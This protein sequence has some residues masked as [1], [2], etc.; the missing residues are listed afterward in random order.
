MN[1]NDVRQEW[2]ERSGEYSPDYYAYYGPDET[3]EWIQSALEDAVDTDARILELGCSS[4]RHLAHLL[5]H[6]YQNLHGIDINEEAFTVMEDAYP[7]LAEQGTFTVDAIESFLPA[8]D[9][10]EFDVVYSVET[11]QHIHPDDSH[12][13]ADIARVASDLVATVEIEGPG[14]D[15]EE[16]V[17]SES[18]ESEAEVN[19][20]DDDV[21]LYYRN[22]ESVFTELGLVQTAS[23]TNRRDTLRAFRP[24]STHP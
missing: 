9:D 17:P 13:F 3:S 16:G 2:A 18:D 15:S 22:W 19:Y 8:L 10:D 6:G 5:D 14:D 20:V 11:L 7:E 24:E 23:T 1:S 21:P 12:V 4:G